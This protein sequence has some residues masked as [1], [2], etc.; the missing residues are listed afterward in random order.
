VSVAPG[1]VCLLLLAGGCSRDGLEWTTPEVAP[2]DLVVS[3]VRGDQ[4]GV[5]GYG[6]WIEI[7]A[8]ADADLAGLEIRV[9]RIDGSASGTVLV[10]ASLPVAP[11]DYAVLGGFAAGE[12]PAHVDQGWLL[13]C[14]GSA[15]GCDD[16]WLD[17]GLYDAAAVELYAGGELIDRAIYRDLPSTGSWAVDG[18][19]APSADGNDDEETWCADQ[20]TDAQSPEQGVRGSPGEANPPC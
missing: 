17:G 18:T 13:P 2:G 6:E 7:Y 1:L 19:A 20:R 8:A 9:R 16:P 3:E 10:R 14:A 4:T 11:G 5:D 12:E 15:S